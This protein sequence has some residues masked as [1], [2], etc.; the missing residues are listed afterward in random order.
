MSQ[1]GRKEGGGSEDCS[2]HIFPPGTHLLPIRRRCGGSFFPPASPMRA[3]G[4]DPGCRPAPGSTPGTWFDIFRTK[5]PRVWQWCALVV[6]HLFITYGMR[7]F[8]CHSSPLPLFCFFF[9][10][11]CCKNNSISAF[12]KAFIFFNNKLSLFCTISLQNLVF[13]RNGFVHY[14]V[15]VE[16]EW[17]SMHPKELYFLKESLCD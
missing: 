6:S 2:P 7:G 5:K 10:D 12:F 16:P 17:Y 8:N 9:F 1:K 11:L 13:C 3:R 14:I 4:W 15:F